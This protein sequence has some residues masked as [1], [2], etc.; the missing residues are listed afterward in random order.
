MDHFLL[1]GDIGWLSVD[2]RRQGFVYVMQAVGTNRYKIGRTSDIVRRNKQ[3]NSNQ[4]PY[5]IKVV[6]SEYVGDAYLLESELHKLYSEFRVNNEWFEIPGVS[7][8]HSLIYKGVLRVFNT[9]NPIVFDRFQ[10]SIFKH[11]PY[12]READ[13]VINLII[14]RLLEGIFCLPCE[15]RLKN[16]E[17]LQELTIGFNGKIDCMEDSAEDYLDET[18]ATPFF[19]PYI[20]SSF[21]LGMLYTD[22]CSL[23]DILSDKYEDALGSENDREVHE[24]ENQ[25]LSLLIAS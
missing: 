1:L 19:H 13:K 5:Q 2:D 23:A 24:N 4:P 12:F 17:Y 21:L 22:I 3:L 15:E 25:A 10:N 18:S 11:L 8:P 7:N 14:E 6:A 9:L 16:R 20:H